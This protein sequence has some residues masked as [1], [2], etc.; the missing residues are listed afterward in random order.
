MKHQT[1]T[2]LCNNRRISLG[3]SRHGGLELNENVTGSE[4]Q[5]RKKTHLAS[6]EKTSEAPSSLLCAAVFKRVVILFEMQ[7]DSLESNIPSSN[8]SCT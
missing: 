1:Q 8:S 7:N 6:S 2:T 5:T 3:S 4:M